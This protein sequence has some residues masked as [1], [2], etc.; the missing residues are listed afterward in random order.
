MPAWRVY[1]GDGSTFSSEDGE[2]K[3]APKRGVQLVARIIDSPN[4]PQMAYAYR[5]DFYWWAEGDGWIGGDHYGFWDYMTQPGAKVVLFGR[6]IKDSDY[7]EIVDRA[8]SE[9]GEWVE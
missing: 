3:D 8:M 5:D 4:G 2:P 9:C 6:S 7:R 1:Y